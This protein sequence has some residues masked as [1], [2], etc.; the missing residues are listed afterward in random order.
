MKGR[1]FFAAVCLTLFLNS[2]LNAQDQATFAPAMKSK[3]VNFPGLPSCMKGSVQ[4]GDP[5][6]GGPLS[7]AKDQQDAESPGIGIRPPNN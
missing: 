6:K 2:N 4:S 7:W 1:L 3:F 5:S